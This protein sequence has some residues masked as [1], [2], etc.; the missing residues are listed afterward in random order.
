MTRLVHFVGSLPAPLTTDDS[1]VLE[2]FVQRSRGHRLT[3]VP[4][5]LDPSWV[6]QYLR[7]RERHDD[8]F[9]VVRGG[10]FA[11]YA[12]MR[13]Y[14]I[15]RGA[16][17]EPRHVAM[18]RVDRIGAAVTA[19]RALRA[20]HPELAGTRL[21]ISQPNPLDLALFVFGGAAVADGLPLVRALRHLRTVAPALRNLPVF[22]EAVLDEM[23][24]VTAEHGE[25]ITW[26]VE[27][28][29]A[30][31]ALVKAARFGAQAPVGRLVAGQL[32]GFLARAHDIGAQTVLHLC[33]GDYQHKE[34]LAPRSLAP[35]VRLLNTVARDLRAR[36]VPLPPAHI[37][38]AYGAHPAPLEP[39]FYRPLRKL[40]PDWRVI[41]GVVSPAGT[42]DSIR[43]LA[44][45]EAAAGR[46]AYGVATACGLGRCTVEEAERAA[47][48]TVT[49]AAAA[50]PAPSD[51]AR[52]PVEPSGDG[53]T[54]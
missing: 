44:L 26:Q 18:D 29:I 41:A 47:E 7:E 51:A 17:L 15:R 3:G 10:D 28:P 16:T 30:Q 25:V 21:Q 14:G 19:F 1:A 52:A 12:D 23:A 37:P 13:V 49:T 24:R 46:A 50:E 42:Q 20:R 33:Y 32:A 6:V 35:A 40:D 54:A 2:W 8:V 4:R 34:L 9:E 43:S 38:C 53:S 36:A 11:D 5:D 31:L 39:A 22:V 48:A 45:F 27:S